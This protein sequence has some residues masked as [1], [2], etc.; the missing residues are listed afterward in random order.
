MMVMIEKAE[1]KILDNGARCFCAQLST[2]KQSAFFW[3]NDCGVRVIV[4]NSSHRV[5]RGMGR[6]FKDAAEALAHYKSGAVKAMIQH[7]D[8]L[9]T[10]AG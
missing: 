5:W 2:E 6:Q 1:R 3:F 9:N 7:A 4:Q 8:E 10:A